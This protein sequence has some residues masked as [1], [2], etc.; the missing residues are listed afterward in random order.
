MGSKNAE[1]NL[2][3]MPKMFEETRTRVKFHS[4]RLA[5]GAITD[6]LR[7]VEGAMIF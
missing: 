2:A 5:G 6:R 7:D 4:T 1:A 3:S